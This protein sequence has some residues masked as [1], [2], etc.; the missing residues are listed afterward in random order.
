MRLTV[1]LLASG[2]KTTADG[3]LVLEVNEP[4]L[5]LAGT[6]LEGEGEDGSTLLDGVLLVSRVVDHTLGD[7]VE[8]LRR[9]VRVELE[10]H[11]D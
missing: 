10:R 2:G 6:V 7:L 11:V 5:L 8:S 1:R 3:T 9:G 4:G